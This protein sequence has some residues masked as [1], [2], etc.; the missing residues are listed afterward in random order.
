M[1]YVVR[2]QHVVWEK[3]LEIVNMQD[4]ISL[5]DWK[6]ILQTPKKKGVVTS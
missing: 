2:A 4:I 3:I 6:F 1:S 5:Q